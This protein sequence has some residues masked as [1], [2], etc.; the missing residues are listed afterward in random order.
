MDDYIH[1]IKNVDTITYPCSN[2]RETMLVKGAPGLKIYGSYKCVP[3]AKIMFAY[4]PFIYEQIY[5]Y[6]LNPHV[7]IIHSPFYIIIKGQS[8]I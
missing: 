8:K 2:P 6:D 1:P 3:S 5:K 4:I 7:C